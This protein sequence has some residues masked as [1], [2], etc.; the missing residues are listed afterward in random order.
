MTITLTVSEVRK[1]LQQAAGRAPSGDGSPSTALLG[2]MF[3]RVISELLRDDSACN[4]ESVVRDLEPD[5]SEWKRVLV[6]HTYDQLLGPLLTTQ[7][8]S[9]REHGDQVMDLWTAIQDAAQWLAELWWQITDNGTRSASQSDSFWVERPVVLDL[10]QPNWSEP[11]ALVG[12]TDAV[13]RHPVTNAWCVLEWKI[14]QTSPVIDL[15][16]VCLYHLMLN[17][18]NPAKTSSAIAVVSFLPGRHETLFQSI[19]IADAQS[20]LMDLIGSTAG[21]TG[22]SGSKQEVSK[23]IPA[24]RPSN[25]APSGNPAFSPAD[26]ANEQTWVHPSKTVVPSIVRK[27]E[28]ESGPSN[29]WL[30][31]NRDKMLRALRRFGAPCREIKSPAIGPTFVRFFLFPESGIR[32]SKVLTAASELQLHM[33]L[34]SEPVLSTIEGAIAVDLANPNRRAFPFSELMMHLPAIDRLFGC[35]KVP[36]G[37]DLSGNLVWCD[38]AVVSPHLLV[39]GTPGSGK[40]QWL[41]AAVAALMQTNTPETLQLLLIDPKQ[42]AFPFMAGSPFLRRP[43]V[44]PGNDRDVS[45][46]LG[47]LVEIMVERNAMLAESRSASLADHVRKTGAALPRILCICD[48]YADLIAGNRSEKQAIEHQFQRIAQVGRAAGIHLILATQ[49]PRTQVLSPSIRSLIDCRVVLRVSTALESRVALESGGAERLLGRGDL[50]FK[51]I[52]T[53]RLQGAWLPEEE[54]SLLMPHQLYPSQLEDFSSDEMR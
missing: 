13:L 54:E 16:Q 8:A 33:G 35:P 3:H 4:L 42:N 32:Q 25:L 36:V 12:Q 45:E 47:E 9:L 23:V 24:G 40:S 53:Q 1:A 43:V 14:G 11:V 52:G 10:Q 26:S 17:G 18:M 6:E 27:P 15:A 51:S 29:E 50:L 30:V 7:S 38:L 2:T 41:R 5:L 31:E 34:S 44:V 21:V 46:I 28:Q 22:E 48:E 19:Q 37:L 49:Q 39:V 20:K